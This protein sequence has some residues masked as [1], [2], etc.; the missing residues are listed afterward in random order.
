MSQ[1]ARGSVL[2]H[3]DESVGQTH[4]WFLESMDRVNRAIQGTHDLDRMM[5]DVLDVVLDVFGGDRAWLAYPC[6]PDAPSWRAMM[7]RSRPEYPGAGTGGPETPM[8]PD[9]ACVVRRMR[10]SDGPVTFGLPP[11]PPVPDAFPARFGIRSV[12]GMALH[13]RVGEPWSFGLHQCSHARVWTTP[14][15]ELFREI[16]RRL[17][18]AVTTLLAF[19]NLHEESERLRLAVQA[20]NVGL[21]DWDVVTNEAM[22]SR[23][24]KQQLGYEDDELSSD[25]VEW[26]TRVHPDDLAP[27]QEDLQAFLDSN[28]TR[29]R[30][31]VPHAPPRRLVALVLRARGAAA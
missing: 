10:E 6:D 11:S 27:S 8:D 3:W 30:P 13:P 4:L 22:F 29:A 20:S 16:G 5:H 28:E 17:A 15:V 1:D 9:T 2:R 26:A 12:M 18:D 19:R 25:Q 24:Y 7:E 31:R 14:E 21:W 23:E